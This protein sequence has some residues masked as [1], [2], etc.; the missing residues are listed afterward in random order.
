MMNDFISPADPVATG[1]STQLVNS[2]L[3]RMQAAR[4]GD[5]PATPAP[6][7]SASENP[8]EQGQQEETKVSDMQ[9]Y[10]APMKLNKFNPDQGYTD[11]HHDTFTENLF[12]DPVF[13][14]IEPLI[15]AF[16]NGIKQGIASGAISPERA[17]M[18]NENF[19]RNVI[20]PI[21]HEMHGP[22]SETH[23]TS[24]LTKKKAEIPQF[25]KQITG[26]K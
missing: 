5:E 3:A 23:N 15:E 1:N 6:T 7:Q 14:K 25:V 24:L 17:E 18:E 4:G 22:H 26:A 13:E 21:V 16:N 19:K 12:N 20:Y 9:R 10:L 2:F 8:E 11:A